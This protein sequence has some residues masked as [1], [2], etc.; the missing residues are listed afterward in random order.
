MK[1]KSRNVRN[2]RMVS[3]INFKD[4]NWLNDKLIEGMNI[5]GITVLGFMFLM[6]MVL[7]SQL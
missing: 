3:G 6:I 4:S 7:T 2:N 1:L 5:A